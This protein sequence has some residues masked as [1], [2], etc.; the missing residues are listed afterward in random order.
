MRRTL[1][2]RFWEKVDVH[3]LD[4][5]WKWL[6]YTS[7]SG[8]G[9]IGVE[10]K[11]KYATHVLFYLRHG[12]WPPRLRLICHHCDNPICL[13]PKHLYLGTYKS[14]VRDMMQRRRN[15][16]VTFKGEQHSNAKLTEREV[17][18]IRRLVSSGKRG[19][20]AKLSRRFKVDP[21]T[22]SCIKLGKL[23]A[24]LSNES[25]KQQPTDTPIRSDD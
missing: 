7:G 13:N 9:Q 17:R 10:G 8:Y 15:H 20:Q 5:C 11:T 16:Y 18:E 14:N 24:H 22:I 4:D 21:S 6:G 12:H 23:W 2:Q 25:N 19:I 1:E 3:G